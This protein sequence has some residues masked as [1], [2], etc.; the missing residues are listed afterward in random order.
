[1]GCCIHK[2]DSPELNQI[3]RSRYKDIK[4]LFRNNNKIAIT[5]NSKSTYQ[6][7][8]FK[9][10]RRSYYTVHINDKEFIFNGK[11]L[12][13]LIETIFSDIANIESEENDNKENILYVQTRNNINMELFLKKRRIN[14]YFNNP[15]IYMT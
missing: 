15:R 1:M 3:Y 4:I 2:Q 8:K 14:D 10:R 12:K 9:Y 11:G 5:L 6:L 13:R 7:Y